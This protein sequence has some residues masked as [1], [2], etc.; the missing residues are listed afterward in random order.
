MRLFFSALFII[1]FFTTWSQRIIVAT[2]KIFLTDSSTIYEGLIVEQ[3]PAKYIK[4]VRT[5]EK[6]TLQLLLKDIW[7]MQRIYPVPDTIKKTSFNNQ[8]I[9]FEIGGSA[10][11]YSLNYD[12]RF[13]KTIANGWGL[14]TGTA[15]LPINTVN[16]SGDKLKFNTILLPLMVSYLFG[17]KNKV[18][19]F[20]S[21]AVYVFKW[22]TGK[23]LSPQY[24]YFIK[25]IN[26]RIP[27]VYGAFSVGYRHQP[28]LGK[29]MWAIN[30]TPLV[31]NS[32]IIPSI[33]I[34]TG[35]LI[36]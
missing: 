6:D 18:I 34:K 32:F 15:Y 12:F 22:H 35:Y 3:A 30:L 8:F 5:K 25:G 19:E 29:F 26:R 31:G 16:F 23:L 28:E 24:D 20:A 21:G 13:N 2:D 17:K 1:C 4:L 9:F 10:G 7:K 36:K 14:R 33:G 11:I 27:H